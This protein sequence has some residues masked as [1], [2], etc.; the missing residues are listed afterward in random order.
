MNALKIIL[1]I[2]LPTVLK[3]IGKIVI[4]KRAET[5][6]V[7]IKNYSRDYIDEMYQKIR[8][9]F[10]KD[11]SSLFIVTRFL[12]LAFII[13]I[14]LLLTLLILFIIKMP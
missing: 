10:S 6:I 7:E 14:I 1:S 12:L 13:I 4:S 3:E 11:I 2:G 8:A 9:E 5:E